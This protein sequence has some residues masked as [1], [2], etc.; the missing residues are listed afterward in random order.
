M[1]RKI[2]TLISFKIESIY[3]E[4]VKIF[5]NKESDLRFSEFDI[6]PLF[7]CFSKDDPKKNCLHTSFTRGEYSKVCASK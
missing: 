7:R 6:K 5:D 1:S 4:W 3:E 2:T